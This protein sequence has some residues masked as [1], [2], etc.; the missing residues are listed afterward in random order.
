MG[1]LSGTLVRPTLLVGTTNTAVQVTPKYRFD[2]LEPA[3]PSGASLTVPTNAW[4]VAVWDAAVWG[5][6][7][8]PLDKFS[9]GGGMG[10]DV[11]L[12]FRGAAITRT[13]IASFDV[14]YEEGGFL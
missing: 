10:R 4:D 9:G 6:D 14:L 2:T 3:P 11:A 8:T 13:V 5:G 12:A 1:S 7:Y